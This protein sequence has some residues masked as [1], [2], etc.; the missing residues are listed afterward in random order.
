[1]ILKLQ[2]HTLVENYSRILV[3]RGYGNLQSYLSTTRLWKLTAVFKYHEAKE[4]YTRIFT[5]HF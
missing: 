5:K 4:T 3:Q 2:K 1:M